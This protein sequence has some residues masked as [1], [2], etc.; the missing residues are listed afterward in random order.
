[1]SRRVRHGVL[2]LT[3]LKFWLGDEAGES[4][5]LRLHDADMSRLVEEENLLKDMVKGY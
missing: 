2:A 1:M 4:E 3:L 5:S